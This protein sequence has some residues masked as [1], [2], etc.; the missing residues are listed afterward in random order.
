MKVWCYSRKS[1]H[2]NSHKAEE[3]RALI[4]LNSTSSPI[5]WTARSKDPIVKKHQYS[6]VEKCRIISKISSNKSNKYNYNTKIDKRQQ[7]INS[8]IDYIDIDNIYIIF[9]LFIIIYQ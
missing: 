5:S 2:K 3:D 4:R 1:A 6:K 8:I 7:M 9:I